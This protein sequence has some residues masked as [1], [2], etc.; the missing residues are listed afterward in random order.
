MPTVLEKP[1]WQFLG[2]RYCSI[3]GKLAALLKVKNLKDNNTYT[4]YQAANDAKLEKLNEDSMSD[5]IDG[6]DV[7]IWNEKGLLLGLAID[8]Q[9][10]I[11]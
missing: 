4:F 9:A 5:I 11:K 2:G 10:L 6:V 8:N 1:D 7:S 3:N